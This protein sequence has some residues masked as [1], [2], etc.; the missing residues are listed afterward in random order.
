M[1][2]KHCIWSGQS[3]D[4]EL[5][6]SDVDPGFG[7]RDRSLEVLCQAA[8]SIEPS[9]GSFD[10]PSPWEQ[11]KSSRV[12]SAFD[13]LDGPVAEFSEGG[14]QVGASVSAVGEEMAQPGKQLVDGL[15][16]KPG[17]IAI[18]D[19][20]GVH[21]GTDQQTAGIGHNVTLTAFDL[22]GRIVTT[23]PAALGRLDRLTVDDPRRWARFTPRRFARLHQQ[24]EIDVLKQAIV[25]P[26]VEIALHRRKRRKVLR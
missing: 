9:K 20:G 17:T 14:A 25:S 26:I 3:P 23:R 7:A 1:C 18:L 22:L 24:L 15:D 5:H 8:V 12:S 16:D 2:D 6:G 13:D 4:E 10:D 21:L 19:V 11:L